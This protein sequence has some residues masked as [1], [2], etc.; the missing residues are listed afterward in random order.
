MKI[1]IWIVVGLGL[2]AF[3]TFSTY[4]VEKVLGGLLRRILKKDRK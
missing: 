3:L 4:P 1:V 2:L